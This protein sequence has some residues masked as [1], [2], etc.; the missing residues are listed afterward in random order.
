MAGSVYIKSLASDPS[1]HTA[2][3]VPRGV[4]GGGSSSS[5]HETD[6]DS[7]YDTDYNVVS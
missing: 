4:G 1:C 7:Q 2:H 5:E 6:T 3:T